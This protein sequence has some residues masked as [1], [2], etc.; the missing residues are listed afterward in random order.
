MILSD[1]WEIFFMGYMLN[2]SYMLPIL[3]QPDITS[4]FR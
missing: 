2:I 4:E 1:F 3:F